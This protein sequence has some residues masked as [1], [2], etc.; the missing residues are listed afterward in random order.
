MIKKSVF[1]QIIVFIGCYELLIY[2][3]FKIPIESL[4][5]VVHYHG[6]VEICASLIN[7]A[8]PL[9][10]VLAMKNH[11]IS[12][13]TDLEVIRGCDGAGSLFLLISAIITFPAILKQK[14]IGLILSIILIYFLTLLRISAL[15]FVMAYYPDWFE[16]SHTFFAPSIVVII[17]CT[18]FAFWAFNSTNNVYKPA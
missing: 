3:Y 2:S 4:T 13:R 11:L 18:Y 9:E 6:I 17:A 15:Y 12:A 16:F 7:T 14:L 1:L 10:Q 5:N 8:A